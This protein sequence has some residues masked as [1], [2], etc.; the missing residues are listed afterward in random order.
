VSHARAEAA[1]RAEEPQEALA[2]R[3]EQ[4]RQRPPSTPL[5]G[6]DAGPAKKRKR[7]V[8]E[9][10]QRAAPV[11]LE[12]Q[13]MLDDIEAER[14]LQSRLAKKLKRYKVCG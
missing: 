9:P 8:C 14:S 1:R 4:R 12:R 10:V 13:R 3:P 5:H 6:D 11:S 7:A 2:E